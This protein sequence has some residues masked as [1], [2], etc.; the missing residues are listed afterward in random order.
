MRNFK[1]KTISVHYAT[2]HIKLHCRHAANTT[3][4]KLVPQQSVFHGRLTRTCN[5]VCSI[6]SQGR[7]CRSSHDDI[8]KQRQLTRETDTDT[9]DGDIQTKAS[10]L[11]QHESQ[12]TRGQRPLKD[13]RL[14]PHTPCRLH[15]PHSILIVN[16]SL[17]A[18]SRNH[19]PPTPSSASLSAREGYEIQT[20][21]MLPTFSTGK[22]IVIQLDESRDQLEITA[23]KTMIL[24]V[25]I[26][27]KVVQKNG[28]Y[29]FCDEN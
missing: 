28:P 9:T 27:H 21:T 19:P 3:S 12:G 6:V 17:V 1:V 5:H 8:R 25:K 26:G 16:A 29:T 7:G 4:G 15:S 24:K 10:I 22:S 11:A 13:Q 18:L 14:R 23:I 20:D 2:Y